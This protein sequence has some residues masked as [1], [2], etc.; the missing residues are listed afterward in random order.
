MGKWMRQ[1]THPCLLTLKPTCLRLWAPYTPLMD[2]FHRSGAI[3][4]SALIDAIR[5][6]KLELLSFSTGDGRHF[7]QLCWLHRTLSPYRMN[8]FLISI[9]HTCLVVYVHH[10]RKQTTGSIL[11]LLD[12]PMVPEVWPPKSAAA[13]I[14]DIG[15]QTPPLCC[16]GS[17]L[18]FLLFQQSKGMLLHVY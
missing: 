12:F 11:I 16:C 3:P 15:P 13:C 8:E 14:R 10:T 17:T 6:T 1:I 2:G 4:R 7:W 9:I 18:E 5:E